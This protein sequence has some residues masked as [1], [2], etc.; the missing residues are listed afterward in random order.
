MPRIKNC[1]SS[2]ATNRTIYI[3]RRQHFDTL[4]WLAFVFVIMAP[5]IIFYRLLLD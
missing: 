3:K 1:G 4:D 2:A 5:I